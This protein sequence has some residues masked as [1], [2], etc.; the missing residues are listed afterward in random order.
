LLK[1]LGSPGLV[2]IFWLV[3]G[4]PNLGRILRW[5]QI[6]IVISYAGLAIYLELASMFPKRAG[7]EVSHPAISKSAAS[8]VRYR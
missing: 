2:L 4:P 1:G 7:A 5:I 8:D 3:S 6:G